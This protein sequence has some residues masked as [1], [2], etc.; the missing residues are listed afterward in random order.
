MSIYE[1]LMDKY[2]YMFSLRNNKRY[3]IGYGIACGPGW[4]AIIDELL[5]KMS[6]ID[7]EKEI[8]IHQ[9]KE[10]FGGL[11]VHYNP[12][13]FKLNFYERTLK[14]FFSFY[15]GIIRN[16]I[17]KFSILS[18]LRLYK[19]YIHY[20]P[21]KIKLIHI[22]IIKAEKLS[23]KTCE[24]CGKPGNKINIDKWITVICDKCLKLNNEERGE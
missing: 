1:K 21:K 17:M 9:I 18:K 11:R 8:Q 6:E 16:L 5:S 24:S 22:E 2:D 23:Y 12:C 19:C 15:N 20:T 7:T 13:E 10:K 14:S 4:Y 3:P